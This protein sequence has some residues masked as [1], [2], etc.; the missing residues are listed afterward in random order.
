MSDTATLNVAILS[1]LTNMINHDKVFTHFDVTRFARAYSD[2]SIRNID[3]RSFINEMFINGKMNDYNR[4]LMDLTLKDGVVVEAVVYFPI[5]KSASD[6]ELVADARLTIEGDDF[7]ADDTSTSANTDSSDLG[8]DEY[9]LTAKGRFQ[10][11]QRLLAQV[12]MVAGSYDLKINNSIV[13]IKPNIGN[14]NR[15]CVRIT[16]HRHG[17]SSNRVKV[18]ADTD[19]NTINIDNA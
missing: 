8:A 12:G 4:Q 13:S 14:D 10:V 9:N 19:A 5:G 18:T 6:H 1:A 17:I 11:P 2:E 15:N 3:V 16:P 7:L